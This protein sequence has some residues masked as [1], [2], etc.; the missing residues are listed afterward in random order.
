MAA[1]GRQSVYVLQLKEGKYYVGT[2]T[3]LERRL[4]EHAAGHR[5]PAWTTVYPPVGLLKEYTGA[6]D[7]ELTVTLTS[8]A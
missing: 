4:K 6:E 8:H 7:T 2:T 3:N 5:R 1:S